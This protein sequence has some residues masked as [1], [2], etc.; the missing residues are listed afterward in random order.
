[1]PTSLV[2]I[3]VVLVDGYAIFK[4]RLAMAK[5]TKWIGIVLVLLA[6][7]MGGRYVRAAAEHHETNGISTTTAISPEELTRRVGELP[8][9]FVDAY[10]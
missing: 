1:M 9:T 3:V 2:G 7:I 5:Q 8:V 4:R 10:F 6:V